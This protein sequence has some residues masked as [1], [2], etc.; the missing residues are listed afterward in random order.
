MV[1]PR[2]QTLSEWL[3][4]QETLH[5]QKIRLGLERVRATA[6]QMS[7]LPLSCPV[8]SV[9]G[10]NGKGS[11]VAM[12]EAIYR[13]AGY[14]T[15]S[16]TSP[17]LLRYNERIRI[18]GQQVEDSTLC[19]AF[20]A[21]DE[22]R[23]D[24]A[25]TYFEFGTL[26]ALHI[27]RTVR[28]DIAILEVGLGGRLDAVNVVDADVSLVTTIGIDHVAWLGTDRN[29]IA[30]EKAGIFRP[31]RPAI[32]ADPCPPD[33]LRLAAVSVGARWYAAGDGF[34]SAG[35]GSR[36]KFEGRSMVWDELPA[37][38]LAGQHQLENAA[39]VL[40]VVEQLLP[41]L[42]VSPEAVRRG[43]ETVILAGRAQRIAGSVDLIVDVAHNPDGAARLATLLHGQPV[44]G[45]TWLVLG[46]LEDKDVAGFARMIG[47]AVDVW[48]LASLHGER[49]LPAD[50]LHRR[51]GQVGEKI[52]RFDT[53]SEALRHAEEHAGEADRIVV[54]GSFQTVAEV[55]ASRV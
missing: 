10:T 19:E 28:P 46:M 43:L 20:A 21:V 31:G 52:L 39:G 25:L 51:V 32:C 47:S 16:Y 55:L 26:A 5:P 44:R 50:E 7:L 48:C 27:V 24:I 38:A 15:A 3:A 18:N 40:A 13:A 41:R 33:S 11:S 54:S 6:E 22:G 1:K 14:H 45:S 34:N 36:W 4:W 8:I 49:G 30:R 9:A 12:L 2:F 37:P 17:H 23:G 35:S 42:P 53:V 29:S